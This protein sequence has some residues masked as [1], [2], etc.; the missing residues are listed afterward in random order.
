VAQEEELLNEENNFQGLYLLNYL[1]NELNF[2][3]V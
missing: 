2:L 1:S 3:G